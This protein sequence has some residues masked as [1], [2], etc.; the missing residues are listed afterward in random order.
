MFSH[1]F[2][3]KVKKIMKIPRRPDQQEV[4]RLPPW[5]VIASAK[6]AEDDDK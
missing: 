3:E 6:A 1:G 2:T 5:P 4:D